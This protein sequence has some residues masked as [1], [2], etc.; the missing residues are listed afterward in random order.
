VRERART[1]ARAHVRVMEREHTQ[2]KQRERERER[3]RKRKRE[4]EILGA[5][6]PLW[7][8]SRDTYACRCNAD[9]QTHIRIRK[10][11]KIVQTRR[12]KG[13]CT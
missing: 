4:R 9:L 5:G 11:R 7:C 10:H 13:T 3:A 12:H 6:Y 1:R 8:G 2:G